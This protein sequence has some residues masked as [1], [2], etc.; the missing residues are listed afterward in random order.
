M[1]KVIELCPDRDLINLKFEKY[2]FCT[3]EI[4]I[5]TEIDLKTGKD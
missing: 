5:E 3:D 1:T 4:P 2:Q